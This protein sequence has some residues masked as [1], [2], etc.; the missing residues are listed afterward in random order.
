MWE[1]G[2]GILHIFYV[3]ARFYR[4]GDLCICSLFFAVFGCLLLFFT[5]FCSI[6]LFVAVFCSFLLIYVF[7]LR[8]NVHFCRIAICICL[9]CN[10]G[11]ICIAICICLRCRMGYC[12]AHVC[13]FLLIFADV[14]RFLYI[15]VY[16]CI[17]LRRNLH[18]FAL[19]SGGHLHCNLHLFAVQDGVLFCIFLLIFEFVCIFLQIAI[20]SFVHRVILGPP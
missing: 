16:F 15:F 1:G 20:C 8:W 14:N 17:L 11:G 19:Q 4:C 6:L 10:R 13:I 9:Q 18:L 5:V 2:G 3:F 7:F 12:F